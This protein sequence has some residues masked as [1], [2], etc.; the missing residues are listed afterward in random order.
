MAL[1]VAG[2]GT[3]W[4]LLV[5]LTAV[6]AGHVD[7][8]SVRRVEGNWVDAALVPIAFVIAV[9]VA[10]G[11]PHPSGAV[12]AIAAAVLLGPIARHREA[13]LRDAAVVAATLSALGA[14]VQLTESNQFL[15]VGGV[16]GLGAA[17][18]AANL[19]RP[20][21]SWIA[22]G[23]ITQAWAILAALA[24]L[25]E[26][27]P[28]HYTPLVGPASAV[29]AVVLAALLASRRMLRPG[30]TSRLLRG[31]AL[32]WAF[33]WLHQEISFAINPTAAT[34]LRVSYYAV[35]SVAAVWVGRARGV[36]VLRH[37]GLGLA[38]I[39]A[40][41]ALYSARH[42][43]AIGARIFADLVAAAFLLAIAFWYRKPG[44]A[45]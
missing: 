40:G 24:L 28:Y 12:L 23:L 16:A 25:N 13:S 21:K 38:V 5:D 18:F 37:I 15:L 41:T 43:S 33:A 22:L 11:A 45:L 35:T 10:L 39:A 1:L 8:G 4:L 2:A 31:G 44:S 42:L 32:V 3:A 34:L 29:A 14:V 19:W 9:L 17:T 30:E 26:R 7:D 6:S 36:A 20:S 27:T